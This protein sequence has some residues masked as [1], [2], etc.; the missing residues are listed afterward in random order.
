MYKRQ[1][2]L[3]GNRQSFF[4]FGPRQTGKST[5]I[6]AL[7]QGQR[8][9]K[10]DF[11]E[12]ETVLKYKTNPSLFRSEAEKFIQTQERPI[13]FIDEVQKV[14]EILDGVQKLLF[15]YPQ[16]QFILTGSSARKLKQGGANLLA[17]RAIKFHLHPLTHLEIG[18]NFDLNKYLGRGSLPPIVDLDEV[19][20]QRILQPYTAT[21]LQEEI[22]H[23]A[24]VRNV[25]PF[26]RFLE[27]AADQNGEMV[28]YSNIARDV[29][30]ASKT[31]QDYYQ[32]LEDT[33]ICF[34]LLPFLKGA[35]KR[36]IKHSK[37]YFFDLGVTNTLCKRPIG[38]ANPGTSLYGRLFEHFIIMEVLRLSDYFE[39]NFSLYH[40]RNAQQAEVDLIIESSKGLMAC[41]I[42]AKE[43][44]HSQ[45]V[46]GLK[47]FAEDY[48]NAQLICISL[49]S[50]RYDLEEKIQVWPW[51]EFLATQETQ[52]PGIK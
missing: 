34:R 28:N 33:L 26:S 46:K 45:D 16:S 35:R 19:S 49:A 44:I 31:V 52:V 23:E 21:Y 15:Q 22:I 5:L 30:I 17:G 11:L 2:E 32:I 1:F 27:I 3:I 43:V 41:E 4:L 50:H 51:R 47:K 25:V 48:P 12:T 42:K 20:A 8:V 36:L 24:L 29:G 14:P 39:K 38:P 13:F 18:Q 40:W 9:F 6:D 7:T 10:I 37:Y